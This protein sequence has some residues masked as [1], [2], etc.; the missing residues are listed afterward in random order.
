MRY[1]TAMGAKI[2]PPSILKDRLGADDTDTNETALLIRISA[3]PPR[4]S[5]RP[6][7]LQ[8]VAVRFVGTRPPLKVSAIALIGGR[9]RLVC[10][11]IVVIEVIMAGFM[12]AP[13][14][15]FLVPFRLDGLTLR[16]P[17]SKL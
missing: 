2:A 5:N 13:A 16:E 1:Q 17:L 4:F 15:G 3:V 12:N 9:G 10:D 14:F 6:E 7:N 8:A 11:D